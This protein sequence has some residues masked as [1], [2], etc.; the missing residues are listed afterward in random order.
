MSLRLFVSAFTTSLCL[1]PFPIDYLF[2]FP[3]RGRQD[4]R[5]RVS[6]D[7][8]SGMSGSKLKNVTFFIGVNCNEADSAESPLVNCNEADSAE[9]P[10]S[11]RQGLYL[12][13]F[14]KDRVRSFHH[15]R[16]ENKN[17]NKTANSP[18]CSKATARINAER[19]LSLCANAISKL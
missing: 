19:L 14:N 11:F 8:F 6:A 18:G 3:H 10:L 1:S 13:S 12:C 4:V 5:G 2:T 17:A 7:E 15:N 16:I 9:S